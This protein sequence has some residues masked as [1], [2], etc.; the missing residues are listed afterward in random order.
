LNFDL[1]AVAVLARAKMATRANA[2]LDQGRVDALLQIEKKM[3]DE[4]GK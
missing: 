1:Q 2:N 3:Q 4:D